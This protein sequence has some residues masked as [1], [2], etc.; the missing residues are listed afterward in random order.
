[1]NLKSRIWFA[2]HTHR[3][4]RLVARLA[5]L[6]KNVHRASEHPGYD[7]QSNGERAVLAHSV[8]TGKPMLFDVGANIGDW[9][10][11][12][13]GVYP[14]ATIHSFELNPKVATPL[15]RRFAGR[16]EIH[17][18]PFGLAAAEAEVEFFAYSGEASVLSGL[19]A[20]LHSHVPHTREVA[21]VRTGNEVC[22]EAGVSAIDYLKVDAEGADLEVLKGFDN[23][24]VKQKIAVIQFEHEG[25]RYLRDFYDYLKPKGYAIGKLYANYVDFQEHRA[26]MEHFLGPNYIAIPNTQKDLMEKLRGGW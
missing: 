9:T 3:R 10:D 8:A 19:R 22:R 12:A 26:S 24:L 17:V 13:L 7:V 23:L 18:H 25:G 6:C 1:M 16:G 4:N 15:A 14:Q 11:M 20:P 2:I 21:T 5:R